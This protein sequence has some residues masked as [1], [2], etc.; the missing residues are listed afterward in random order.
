MRLNWIQLWKTRTADGS[1]GIGFAIGFLCLAASIFI[2]RITPFIS[3]TALFLMKVIS[4]AS[5]GLFGTIGVFTD[6]KKDGRLTEP[7][8]LNVGVIALSVLIG[9]QVQTSEFLKANQAAES[10]RKSEQA[11]KDSVEVLLGTTSTALKENQKLL[12]EEGKLLDASSLTNKMTREALRQ[13]ARNLQPLPKNLTA[14]VV[15][16]LPVNQR[17]VAPYVARLNSLIA[18]SSFVPEGPGDIGLELFPNKE[19]FDENYLARL[20]DKL[21][22]EIEFAKPSQNRVS[23]RLDTLCGKEVEAEEGFGISMSFAPN[24]GERGV[25]ILYCKNRAIVGFD[26]RSFLSLLDFGNASVVVELFAG[27]TD[28]WSS[29]THY[30]RREHWLDFKVEDVILYADDKFIELANLTEDSCDGISTCFT[31]KLPHDQKWMTI[32]A[33]RGYGPLLHKAH[34][35]S[36]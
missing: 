7:G 1:F 15:V 35:P 34:S 2:W 31:T 16:S 21:V 11:A 5:T 19:T 12:A 30:P 10:A 28:R 4:F 22:L 36:R 14:E 26:D 24:N 6:F 33:A 13:A 9:I 8:K 25:L 18:K 23:L 17:G 29:V 32:R 27:Q 3:D 20:T